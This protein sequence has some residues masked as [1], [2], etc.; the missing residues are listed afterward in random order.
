MAPVFQRQLNEQ[1]LLGARNQAFVTEHIAGFETVKTLQMKPQ[2]RQRYSGYLASLLASAFQTKQVANT[3]N[4]VANGLQQIMTLAILITG[5]WM[6]MN[7]KP[8]EVFTVGMLVAL[9]MFSGKLSEPVLRIVG[10]W[11]QFQQAS[12]SVQRLGDVMNAS[13][14]P[15]SLT[16]QRRHDGKGLVSVRGLGFRYGPDRPYLYQNLNL[17]L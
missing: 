13:T 14:E 2:L 3:Y 8:D 7:P 15:Y 1:F 6:V 11:T 5:A 4:T 17:T 12:L 9:Q 16:P 10:L